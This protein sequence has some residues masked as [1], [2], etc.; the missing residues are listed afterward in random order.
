MCLFQRAM[1]S[2]S[3]WV[4]LLVGRWTLQPS[5]PNTRRTCPACKRTPFCGW[6][7]SATRGKVQRSL[8][9]PWACAPCSSDLSNC[10]LSFGRSLQG[11]PK[12]RRF[13]AGSRLDRRCRSHRRAVGRLTPQCC[14][15]SAWETPRP[16][17]CIPLR[18]LCSMPLRF[19]FVIIFMREE[20]VTHLCDSQ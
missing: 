3:S 18:R 20:C 15:T 16:N 6:I 13:R 11:H 7:S 8:R 17:N 2:S 5:R 19:R 9:K 12:G 14:A 1:A 4:A 10:F